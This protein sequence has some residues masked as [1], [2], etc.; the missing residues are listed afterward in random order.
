MKQ[1]A[2]VIVAAVSGLVM[3]AAFF[4]Q[5]YTAPYLGLVLNWAIIVSSVAL[6]VAI[7]SLVV[8]HIRFIV[9]GRKGFLYSIVL[10][11]AFLVTLGLGWYSGLDDPAY[12][13]GIRAILVPLE[14][15]L[16][17]L[18]ALVLMSAAVKIF[19][20]RGWSILTVSFGLSA[21]VFLFLN[22]GFL[23]FEGNPGMSQVVSMIQ[24]LPIVGAR[25]LLIGVAL[26]ALLM[27]LRVL[28]GQEVERE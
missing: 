11:V 14:N 27:A 1:R 20:V 5:P 7:A 19:R 12:L 13:A 18:V 17:A 2:P 16:M 10:V 8:I 6:L 3:L 4:F 23:R 28:F 9:K 25:G 15:A 26:G 21:L 22:L 24:R